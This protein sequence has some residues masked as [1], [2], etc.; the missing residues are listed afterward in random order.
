MSLSCLDRQHLDVIHNRREVMFSIISRYQNPD[1]L[2]MPYMSRGRRSFL[3]INGLP[4]GR[5]GSSKTASNI[6]LGFIP[7]TCIGS[8]QKWIHPSL[9]WKYFKIHASVSFEYWR[10]VNF[11]CNECCECRNIASTRTY[12]DKISI[13]D[14]FNV[15]S[16]SILHYNWKVARYNLT[17][18]TSAMGRKSDLPVRVPQ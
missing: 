2:D 8:S 14:S 1:A 5:W 4:S 6:R 15:C 18:Y 17:H 12:P 9:S 13:T 11:H 10:L 3:P 16:F 7:L